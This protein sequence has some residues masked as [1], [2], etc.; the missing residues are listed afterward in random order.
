MQVN[1]TGSIK[2]QGAALIKLAKLSGGSLTGEAQKAYEKL[3][4]ATDSIREDLLI[5]T[6][7]K[8]G[9]KVSKLMPLEK[10][11]VEITCSSDFTEGLKKAAQIIESEI[12][13]PAGKLPFNADPGRQRIMM[14]IENLD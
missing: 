10:D 6:S 13:S 1:F 7:G 4:T 14:L 3:K 2:I 12:P 11:T 5:E 9:I 8:T